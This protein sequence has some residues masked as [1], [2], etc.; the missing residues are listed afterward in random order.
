MERR[1]VVLITAFNEEQTIE[2]VI[3]SALKHA[4]VIVVNDASIDK[5]KK[6]AENSGAILVNLEKNLGYDGALNKGFKVASELGYSAVVTFDADGQHD[7]NLIPVFFNYLKKYDLVLGIRS[8][9][10]RLGEKLFGFA[11]FK[12]LH[13]KDPLCGMKGYS[14][15][16]YNKL[17]FF[18][19][20]ESIGTELSLFGILNKHKFVEVKMPVFQRADSS[21][22]Y[23][24]FWSNVKII[25]SLLRFLSK[26]V[27]FNYFPRIF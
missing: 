16:L 21:R 26:Y 17:G 15:D 18:D 14:I 27:K 1:Q 2:K 23:S 8:H 12:L 7:S 10:S 6:I 9:Q 25:K 24:S 4:E 20:C 13:W 5:T 22:F 19:S 3:S 11:T